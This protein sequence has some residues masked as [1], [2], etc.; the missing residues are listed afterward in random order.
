MASDIGQ[1]GVNHKDESSQPGVGNAQRR[2]N[3][4]PPHGPGGPLTTIS[5]QE[6]HPTDSPFDDPQ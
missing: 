6:E 1:P 3:R 2:H 5:S 4:G